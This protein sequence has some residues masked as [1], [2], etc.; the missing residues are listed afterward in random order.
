MLVFYIGWP[1]QKLA[2]RSLWG[3]FSDFTIF[4]DSFMGSNGNHLGAP[5]PGAYRI[6]P[7]SPMTWNLRVIWRTCTI[8]SPAILVPA[9]LKTL[10]SLPERF[11][12][13]NNEAY[14]KLWEGAKQIQISYYYFGT[15]EPGRT[16]I[17][18]LQYF[19]LWFFPFYFMLLLISTPALQ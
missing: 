15:Q 3:R 9:P 14:W 8:T 11:P 2:I 7:F 5:C 6:G 13:V 18:Q 12:L 1:L 10:S 4:H 19:W 16:N 17:F